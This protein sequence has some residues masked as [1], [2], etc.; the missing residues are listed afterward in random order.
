MILRCSY[1][2]VLAILLVPPVQAAP[3]SGDDAVALIAAAMQR[4][5]VAPP[6]MAAPLRA[7]PRCDHPPEVSPVGGDWALAALRCAA[8]T[9][10]QRV[11]RTGALARARGAATR[12]QAAPSSAPDAQMVLSLA[13][14]VPRGAR[15]TPDDLTLVAFA[16][17]DPAQVLVDP[18][19]ATGRRLRLAVGAGQALL[20][21]H[22]EPLLDVEPAQTLTVQLRAAS[23]EIATTATAI[24]GG[25]IG[26]RITIRPV[27]GGPPIE[28][29]ITAAGIVHVRANISDD[30]AVRN[31]KRREPWSE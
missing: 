21:R 11:L 4:D 25:R 5:G 8:P 20:E 10:W 24:T 12:D 28:A 26:D 18:A 29:T 7:L 2:A 23:I 17:L 6:D 13:R 31:A 27:F 1:L 19:H 3:I 16:G 14:P 15:I 22:L 30:P 9:A